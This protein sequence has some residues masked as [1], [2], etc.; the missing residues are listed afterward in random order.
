MRRERIL[1]L[2]SSKLTVLLI[3]ARG[4]A[5]LS[6]ERIRELARKGGIAAHAKGTAHTFTREEAIEAGRKGG[7][8]AHRKRG[9]AKSPEGDADGSPSS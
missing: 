8:A 2:R 7:L 6:P 1:R 9:P 4:F 5:S 3:M